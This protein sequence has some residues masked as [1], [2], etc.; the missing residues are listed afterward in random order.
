[1][2]QA[3]I[4]IHYCLPIGFGDLKYSHAPGVGQESQS[5]SDARVQLDVHPPWL[6]PLMTNGPRLQAQKPSSE[7]LRR[8]RWTS[9]PL[10]MALSVKGLHGVIQQEDAMAWIM[11]YRLFRDA[12]CG[13]NEILKLAALINCLPR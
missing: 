4:G 7:A 8:D 13:A 2:K 10:H 5:R 11:Q 12:E 3:A 6:A 1:M 9:P